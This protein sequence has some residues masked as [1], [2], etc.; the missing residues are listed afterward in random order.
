MPIYT[1][2]DNLSNS[3]MFDVSRVNIFW[4]ITYSEDFMKHL[5]FK[6]FYGKI[7]Y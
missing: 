3:A 1:D 7:T 6:L 2:N 5:N 4:N